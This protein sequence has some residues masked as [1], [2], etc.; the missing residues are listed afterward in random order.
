MPRVKIIFPDKYLTT[1]FIPI[2]ITDI[3]YGNHLGN[4]SFVS[5]IH[6]A[7]VQFLKEKGFSELNIGGAGLIM[8]DLAIEFKGEA[9]YGDKIKIDIGADEITNTSFSLY[10]LL[11]TTR[12][13]KNI[14]LAKARTNMVCYN[15]ELKK[16][17]VIPEEFK[18]ILLLV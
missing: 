18:N 8:S 4:D 11:S 16:I 17:S 10:Y 7:R 13:G 1:V 2:R 5:I 14:I 9:F 12:E 3:N 6:E 15:Y